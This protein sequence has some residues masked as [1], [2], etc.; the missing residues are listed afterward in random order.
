MIENDLIKSARRRLAK[1]NDI[2][3][4]AD[5]SSD[6]DWLRSRIEAGALAARKN[7]V[8]SEVIVLTPGLAR[9][10]LKR[11][12][13]NRSIKD[14]KIKEFVSDILE[15]KF[16]LN[17]EP[18]IVSDKGELNDG[19]HRCLAVIEAKEPIR[20][21]IVFGV[22]RETRKTVD[23]GINRTIGD[24]LTFN[25]VSN[26]NAVAAI[27]SLLWQYE[28][29]NSISRNSYDRP[30][31]R[32]VV[33]FVHLRNEEIQRSCRIISKRG[34]NLVGG[35]SLV[36]FCHVVFSRIDRNRA[37]YFITKFVNGDELKKNDPIFACRQRFLSPNRL[38]L[39]EK[40]GLIFRAWN[41][42]VNKREI[43]TLRV[44][45]SPELPKLDG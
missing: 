2:E 6:E 19:Q 18:L 20:T 36:G 43:T 22:A 12:H 15:K 39:I 11:N 33:E 29:R 32:Q 17:G 3:L 25:H 8:V 21:L 16:A 13:D 42:F 28:K 9:L 35:L 34:I 10:L 4:K 40:A 31:R 23:Q 30:N 37:D 1:P 38:T 7:D 44:P 14:Y 45:N 41:A 5:F 27:A 26:A 24:V